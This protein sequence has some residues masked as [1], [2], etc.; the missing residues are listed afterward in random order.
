MEG[1]GAKGDARGGEASGNPGNPKKKK[2]KMGSSALL[3]FAEDEWVDWFSATRGLRQKA[4]GE[5]KKNMT[6]WKRK[7]NLNKKIICFCS[8]YYACKMKLF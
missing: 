8:S 4:I 7:Q 3:S 2:A 1:V 5:R 6:L